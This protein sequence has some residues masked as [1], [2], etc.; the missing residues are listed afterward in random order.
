MDAVVPVGSLGQRRVSLAHVFALP[1]RHVAHQQQPG[2]IARVALC[3][4]QAGSAGG[5]AGDFVQNTERACFRTSRQCKFIVR[6]IL[7]THEPESVTEV[8][9]TAQV[10][11]VCPLYSIFLYSNVGQ[12]QTTGRGAAESYI[13]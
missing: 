12:Q 4:P 7:T 8:D 9:S 1:Q 3:V 10:P 2:A 5:G 11:G 13:R 6:P